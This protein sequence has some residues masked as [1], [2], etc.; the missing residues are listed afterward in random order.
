MA[1]PQ[2]VA[3]P[4]HGGGPSPQLFGLPARPPAPGTPSSEASG[5]APAAHRAARGGGPPEAPAPPLAL[6]TQVNTDTP[7]VSSGE[8]TAGSSSSRRA[9]AARDSDSDEG[10][11]EGTR[12]L[13]GARLSLLALALLALGG[14]AADYLATARPCWGDGLRGGRDYWAIS[15]PYFALAAPASLAFAAWCVTVRRRARPVPLH[16]W[17]QRFGACSTAAA[18]A[19]LAQPVLYP[20]CHGAAGAVWRAACTALT[21]GAYLATMVLPFHIII[22]RLRTLRRLWTAR[23]ARAML[24]F[25]LV[26]LLSAGLAWSTLFALGW[27]G[28]DTGLVPAVLHQAALV[29]LLVAIFGA[30]TIACCGTVGLLITA[31]RAADSGYT[32]LEGEVRWVRFTAALIVA[33]TL[34]LCAEGVLN[35]LSTSNASDDGLWYACAWAHAINHAFNCLQVACLSGLSGPRSFRRLAV[36][37]F[38][39]VNPYSSG[40]LQQRYQEFLIYLDDAQIKWV[41]C[42]Y[43]RRL[44]EAGSTMVRCQEVPVAEA[45]IGSEGLPRSRDE[46][47]HRYAVSH[48]WFSKHHP[49]PDGLKLQDLVEQLD[50]LSASDDDAVFI[51]YM[52][53]PQHD[54]QNQDLQRLELAGACPEPGKH[55]AVRSE[56]DELLFKKALDSMQALYSVG[57]VPVIILPLGVNRSESICSSL[58]SSLS[59]S[60]R[61]QTRALSMSNEYLSRGWCFFE[62]SLALAYGNIANSVTSPIVKIPIRFARCTLGQATMFLFVFLQA[63][64]PDTLT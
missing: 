32:D 39:R 28:P 63:G 20:G 41:R 62:F 24:R 58:R 56:T 45:V 48:P 47:K 64:N 36:D 57:G 14:P 31:A 5:P 9:A 17:T 43:L 40:E 54:M 13:L 21:Y 50:L 53:L 38:E 16:A 35:V 30:I 44:A 59:L 60:S 49:D 22:L 25:V 3:P 61:A 2:S 46:P 11:Q 8:Q 15:W 7:T 51:D 27:P 37:S 55:P 18:V 1:A 34:L 52:G 12:R 6:V 10:A 42:R 23:M 19:W 26:C 33:A 4:P 29:G